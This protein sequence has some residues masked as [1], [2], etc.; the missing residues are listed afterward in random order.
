ML[1][2]TPMSSPLSGC[3]GF[4]LDDDGNKQDADIHEDI[5][6]VGDSSAYKAASR[7]VGQNIGISE[8]ILD[9]IYGSKTKGM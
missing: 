6:S 4:Y 2:A 5:L 8:D 9:Q 1:P 3:E 7:K